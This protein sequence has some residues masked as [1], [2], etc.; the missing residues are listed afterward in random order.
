LCVV[1]TLACLKMTSEMWFS[2]SGSV[3]WQLA[4]APGGR[5]ERGLRSFSLHL[6]ASG[7]AGAAAAR[8]EGF[9]RLRGAC[10]GLRGK[11]HHVRPRRKK[12]VPRRAPARR[13]LAREP[14]SLVP[15]RSLAR[16]PRVPSGFCPAPF[17]AGGCAAPGWSSHLAA[18]KS[19]RFAFREF[20]SAPLPS[21]LR[22][23]GRCRRGI[24]AV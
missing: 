20:V 18:D 2:P 24:R 13:R 23:S 5:A 14:G 9:E 4:G 10:R 8:T 7:A 15:S 22:L 21:R 12:P 17:S 19:S 6:R 11:E 1:L 3:R 16:E